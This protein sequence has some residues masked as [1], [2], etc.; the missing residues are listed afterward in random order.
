MKK[1]LAHQQHIR[2]EDAQEIISFITPLVAQL[3]D[4]K[5]KA[6]K[7]ALKQIKLDPEE[8][9]LLKDGKS[10]IN[11]S[12]TIIQNR[13]AYLKSSLKII[14]TINLMLLAT[15]LYL[16][17]QSFRSTIPEI[18]FSIGAFGSNLNFGKEGNVF[19]TQKDMEKHIDKLYE[20]SNK[21]IVSVAKTLNANSIKF[22]IDNTITD[23]SRIICTLEK[24]CI[25]IKDNQLGKLLIA[26]LTSE[27]TILI[28]GDTLA[29]YQETINNVISAVTILLILGFIYLKYQEK[30]SQKLHSSLNDFLRYA[31]LK[32]TIT[33]TNHKNK[34]IT[35]TGNSSTTSSYPHSTYPT[36]TTSKP[37]K[38]KT[39][40]PSKLKKELLQI[41]TSQKINLPIELQKFLEHNKKTKRPEHFI[42][43]HKNNYVKVI[44]RN[45]ELDQA[46]GRD[47]KL[48]KKVL[49][50]IESGFCTKENTQG[51]H[52]LYNKKYVVKLLGTYGDF[53]EL[54][55]E[56]SPSKLSKYRILVLKSGQKSTHK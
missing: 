33:P 5:G 37:S 11:S 28:L 19:Q 54:Q 30:Q 47:S 26:A 41:E 17:Y 52:L 51:L 46:V 50:A 31:G 55:G 29:K 7:L 13:Q 20:K 24:T 1:T 2:Y 48:E 40:K 18:Q 34:R 25:D 45:E 22:K 44:L 53:R 10:I 38:L 3:P 15:T 8:R 4:K 6:Y 23:N 49:T 32:E 39:K 9:K 12:M 42:I 27:H 36:T 56:L 35:H 43:E 21:L 16:I 14:I